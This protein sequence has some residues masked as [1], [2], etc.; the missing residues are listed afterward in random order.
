M[1]GE[2]VACRY[3]GREWYR[4]VIVWIHENGR[5]DVRFEDGEMERRVKPQDV[6]GWSWSHLND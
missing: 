1:V 6:V 4:G 2:D 5:F 3:R